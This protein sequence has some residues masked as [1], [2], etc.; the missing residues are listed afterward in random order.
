[1]L[2]RIRTKGREM[3]EETYVQRNHR[4]LTD[5]Q[6]KEREIEYQKY[7]KTLTE[8]DK[9]LKNHGEKIV[10][11][12]GEIH[13]SIVENNL[14]I[15]DTETVLGEVLN[16]VKRYS[17]AIPVA[18]DLVDIRSLVLSEFVPSQFPAEPR[19]EN[20]R[21]VRSLPTMRKPDREKLADE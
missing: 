7:H 8:F 4:G 14:S 1:M 16:R 6:E 2:A 10:R 18:S 11:V 21:W 12:I 17:Q 15:S 9:S 13:N 5:E 20:Q 19:T 3:T